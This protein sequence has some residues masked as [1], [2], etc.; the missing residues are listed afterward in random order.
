MLKIY[1]TLQDTWEW[2]NS[3]PFPITS[4]LNDSKQT[5]VAIRLI[6]NCKAIRL[7]STQLH[8][9]IFMNFSAKLASVQSAIRVSDGL[10]ARVFAQRLVN[11]WLPL[12]TQIIIVFCCSS[13]RCVGCKSDLFVFS[14]FNDMLLAVVLDFCRL[15]AARQPTVGSGDFVVERLCFA[16]NRGQVSIIQTSVCGFY[17]NDAG[18]C[19]WSIVKPCLLF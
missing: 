8:R 6:E 4:L 9:R 10:A 12:F 7:P 13:D 1:E 18:K 11:M 17:Y 5:V 15:P 14:N 3:D 16:L 19:C 2:Y